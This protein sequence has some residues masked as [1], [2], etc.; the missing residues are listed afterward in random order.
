M[1]AGPVK[2]ALLIFAKS[3][4]M[5]NPFLCLLQ[6]QKTTSIF[7]FMAPFS[8]FKV[9]IFKSLTPNPASASKDPGDYT[10]PTQCTTP[11]VSFYLKAVS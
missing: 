3:P 10:G 9:R 5:E 11:R 6:I 8:S 2:Q 1:E 4:F 7:C